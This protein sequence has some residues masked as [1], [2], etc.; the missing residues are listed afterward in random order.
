MMEDTDFRLRY[1]SKND[2]LLMKI[3]I[4]APKILKRYDILKWNELAPKDKYPHKKDATAP[5]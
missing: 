3:Y 4:S 5:P 2:F 1:I